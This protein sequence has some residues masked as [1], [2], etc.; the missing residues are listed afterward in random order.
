MRLTFAMRKPKPE[1]THPNAAAFP[2]GV[3]GPVLRALATAG[4]RSMRGLTRWTE[5]DLA[6]LHG[7]GPKGIRILKEALAT[8]P[9][10]VPASTSKKRAKD[11]GDTSARIRAYL[12]AQPP[13]AR[14]ELRTI[15]A[16]IRASAPNAVEAF[17]YGIPGFRLED[18]TLVW[19]AGWK[20]HTSLYPITSA[21]RK[22]FADE[23]KGLKVS[24]GT[25]QFPL[26][27][28]VP[29]ALVKRLVKA[30]VAEVKAARAKV[31][32]R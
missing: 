15:R 6:A 2:A 10:I 5:R 30:R 20:H 29:A 31:R 22:T 7:M 26:S 21:I 17:S 24:T 19:Y 8:F 32:Q 23:L 12:A 13:A 3:G 11:E 4:I 1:K 9:A 16:A 14:R 28:P 25:V 27:D 18:K